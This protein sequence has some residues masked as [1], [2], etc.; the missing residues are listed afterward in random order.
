MKRFF[1]LCRLTLLRLRL[2]YAAR[3][4]RRVSERYYGWLSHAFQTLS[5]WD[6]QYHAEVRRDTAAGKEPQ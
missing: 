5:E 1:Y 2:R 4:I 3:V 6:C